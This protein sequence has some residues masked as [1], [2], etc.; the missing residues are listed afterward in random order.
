[1]NEGLA[2]TIEGTPELHR[3]ED[4]QLYTEGAQGRIPVRVVRCFPWAE[5]GRYVSLR[6]T[7]DEEVALIRDVA[8]LKNGSRRALLEALY[9]AGFVL[10]IEA[11]L[12]VEEEIEIRTFEVRTQQGKRRFQTLRDEWP[13]EMP[14]GSL[15][16]TDVVGDLYRVKDPASL[17]PRSRKLLWAFLD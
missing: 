6:D 14:G 7:D 4:G 2:M 1:M 11:V 3:S 12:A 8:D 16:I 9:E 5:P 15:V 17:D 13:R 10:E